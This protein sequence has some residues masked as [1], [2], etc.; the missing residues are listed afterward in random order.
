MIGG[1][2]KTLARWSVPLA[3]S[4]TVVGMPLRS[5]DAGLPLSRG[6]ASPSSGAAATPQTSWKS[7][8]GRHTWSMIERRQFA[9]AR[10][11]SSYVPLLEREFGPASSDRDSL[12]A[13]PPLMVLFGGSND[14]GTLILWVTSDRDVARVTVSHYEW[15]AS[16]VRGAVD[17][18]VLGSVPPSDWS[19]ITTVALTK[20]ERVVD[21]AKEAL[22]EW[23]NSMDCGAGSTASL[24]ILAIVGDRLYRRVSWC[25][26]DPGRDFD[27]PVDW[28]RK[29]LELADVGVDSTGVRF[30]RPLD[31]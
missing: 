9:H 11:F 30:E 1:A 4:I 2:A 15:T 13:N 20:A 19:R 25:L 26:W 31:E 16:L 7:E 24:S 3:V 21:E 10:L 6:T 17:R 23:D 12:V 18:G 27:G 5:A 14:E 29:F 8:H 28:V 22:V